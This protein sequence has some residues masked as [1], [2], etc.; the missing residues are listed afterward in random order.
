MIDRAVLPP[1]TDRRVKR[2]LPRWSEFAPLLKFRRPEFNARRRRLERAITIDDLR[3]A[4][5]RRVPR[6]VFD[7]VDGAAEQEI[8]IARAREAFESVQFHP[9]VLRDVSSVDTSAEILGQRSA[10]PLVLAPTGFTR[11]MNHEGEIAV[12]RAA[13]RAGIPYTLSTMGTTDLDD[14]R[15][16]APDARQWFQLYLWR[17]RDISA[18]LVDRAAAAGYEALVL[19]VDT[20]VG[21][22]RL[23]DARNGLTIPPALTLSTFAGMAMRPAWWI[24]VLTT[25]PIGFAAMRGFDGTAAELVARMFDPALTVDDLAWLRG[26]WPRK[27]VIKGIQSVADAV[28]ATDLGVDA[29]VLSNHGGRQLDRTEPPLELLP[30]VVDAVGDRCEVLID[31]GVRT[32]ADLVAARALGASA[33]L[34]GRPYLYGLMAGGEQGVDRALQILRS[35]YVRTMQLMGVVRTDDLGAEHV[36]LRGR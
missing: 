36:S 23:R 22:A 11:M 25:E 15:A 35:E 19:T 27:L 26:H 2:R 3:T 34:V 10:L 21:G 5:K 12:A 20:P 1:S 29:I 8:S 24:D 32:G 17:E 18:E 33:A 9:R 6:S 13:A 7:Y 30:R 31:T 4:A 16:C 28:M 14:V